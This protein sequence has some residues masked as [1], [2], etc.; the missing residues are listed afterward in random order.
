MESGATLVTGATGFAG[1][2]L[3]ECLKTEAAVVAWGRPG[4]RP[5][6][7]SSTA[8]WQAVDLTDREDVARAIAE[9]RP[10]RIFHLAGAPNVATSWLNPVGQLSVNAL[11][12]HYLLEAVRRAGCPCRLLV[13]SS[14]QIYRP[15]EEPIDEDA[16]LGPSNPYGFSKL[17][18]DQLALRASRDEHVD[19]VLARPFN[20]VGPRQQ[21]GFA[22]SSFARQIARIEL[23]LEA[24]RIRVGNLE[25]RRDITDVRDV[26]RAYV[27]MME[28]AESGRAYNVCSGRSW[29][30]RDLLHELLHLARTTIDVEIDPTRFRP[31]DVPTVQGDGSRLRSELGWTPTIRVEQTLL[32][33]LA[34][35][36]DHAT[37]EG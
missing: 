11:G 3:V 20:H 23:G 35:W 32:D 34:W 12:T 37:S 2:H 21:P 17:A 33:T 14:G 30:I 15:S 36:R 19:I 16:P 4:G 1:G 6:P 31:N 18:Q 10:S 22:V 29:R 24:P 8:I 7:G 27:R 25:A 28:A 13:V 5:Q 26:V 9:T